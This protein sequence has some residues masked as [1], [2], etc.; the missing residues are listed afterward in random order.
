MSYHSMQGK[1]NIREH[2]NGGNLKSLLRNDRNLLQRTKAENG[3]KDLSFF[4]EVLLLN[5]APVPFLNMI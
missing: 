3:F 4:Y 1:E 2:F 5:V